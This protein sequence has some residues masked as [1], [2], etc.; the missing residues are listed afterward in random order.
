M[1]QDEVIARRYAKG[2]AEYAADAGE[3]DAVRHDVKLVVGL[4]D[5]KAGATYVPEL[6][7]FLNSPT[8]SAQDKQRAF[9][10]MMDKAGIGKA[11]SDFMGVLIERGRVPLLPKIVAAFSETAGEMTGDR[12]AVV[13]TARALTPEQEGRLQAVLSSVCGGNVHIRQ[14]IEPGL[15][16]GA[17]VT[18]GDKTFDGSVLGKL[19]TMRRRLTSGE[20]FA[21]VEDASDAS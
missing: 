20:L 13:H 7:A 18:L 3:M 1:A 5:P 9:A 2:L 12:T 6:S 4:L 15:L 16:A 21:S 14:R 8:A 11:V 17:K 19:E 10:R